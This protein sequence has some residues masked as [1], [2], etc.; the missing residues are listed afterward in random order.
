[1]KENAF[2][3]QID[4]SNKMHGK[5]FFIML[6]RF[7]DTELGKVVNRFWESKI[8]N[9]GDSDSLVKAI[10]T[11]FEEHDVPFDNLFQIMPDSPNVMR[12]DHKRSYCPNNKKI[13]SS[14]N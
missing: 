12:G 1:M 6:V 9:K 2:S 8:T 13:C 14:F 7:Y 5:K 11:T 10:T 4:E 3:L